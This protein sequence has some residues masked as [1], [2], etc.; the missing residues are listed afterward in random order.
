WFLPARCFLSAQRLRAGRPMSRCGFCG[1]EVPGKSRFC[2]CCGTPVEGFADPTRTS[3][4]VS[5]PQQAVLAAAAE[6][7]EATR[8]TPRREGPHDSLSSPSSGGGR[9]LPGTVL[10]GRYRIFGLLGR[11]GMGEVY[12]ADDIKLGQPVALKF[13][14]AEMDRDPARL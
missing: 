13:L 10:A 1:E 8:L 14:P 11:G 2:G 3:L 4:P 7:E 12:R 6:P 9:F 5:G